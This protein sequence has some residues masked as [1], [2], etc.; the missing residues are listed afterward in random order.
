MV[1]SRA[2]RVS[3]V[4]Y[5]QY[6]QHCRE[7][8]ISRDTFK[9]P[10]ASARP[11][12]CEI[13]PDWIEYSAAASR[14]PRSIQQKR[15][16]KNCRGILLDGLAVP[17]RRAKRHRRRYPDGIRRR[18][19]VSPPVCGPWHFRGERRNSALLSGLLRGHFEPWTAGRGA[20]Q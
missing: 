15:T 4:G 16:A 13:H 12:K 17:P 2:I 19:Q 18:R 9:D 7:E 10:L 14:R 6:L 5:P 11:A 3:R 1:R 20:D 8:H